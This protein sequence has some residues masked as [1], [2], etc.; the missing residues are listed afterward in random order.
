MIKVIIA[1][2]Q[3]LFRDL[4]EHM[5]KGSGDISVQA[6]VSTGCEAV[7][8]AKKHQ[9]DVILMDVHMP[10]CSGID[11]VRTIKSEGLDIKV[12]ML[13]SSHEEDDVAE[14]MGSGAD[15][16][17]LKSISK[18][19]LILAIKSVHSGMSVIHQDARR[20]SN[21]ASGIKVRH[22]GNRTIVRID[23]MDVVLTERDIRIISMLIEG[24]TSEEMAKELFLAE[25]RL[26]N[27]ITEMLSK[28]MLKD[29]T[30]LAVFALKNKLAE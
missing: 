30:Q 28:L 21:S 24:K 23:E 9:A 14:A 20:L 19:E 5:L 17:V 13:T 7:S 25:G 2:D 1:D 27:V 29:R 11:A 6:A 3:Q 8:E 26:R 18:D 16:Y 12:L 15:G 4:L 22:E 10:E